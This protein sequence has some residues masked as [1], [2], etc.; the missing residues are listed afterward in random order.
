VVGLYFAS[1]GS[2]PFDYTTGATVFHY[3]NPNSY[4]LTVGSESY[5]NPLGERTYSVDVTGLV[6][7]EPSTLFLLGTGLFGMAGLFA[8]RVKAARGR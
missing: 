2:V 3:T 8:R 6:I 5:F 4:D 7:P 1:T